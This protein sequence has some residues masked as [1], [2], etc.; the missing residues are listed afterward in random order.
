MPKSSNRYTL[1][2]VTTLCLICAGL[3]SFLAST[4][5]SKQKEA[6][7]LYQSKQMLIAARI[8][9]HRGFFLEDGVPVK[10]AT[11]SEITTF[12]KENIQPRLTDT[13]GNL[14]TFEEAGIDEE[15]YR[16][17][18]TKYGFSKL[19]YKLLYL[20]QKKEATTPD[21][22]IIPI[23]GYGLWD[24]IYGYIAIESDAD[25]ILGTTWYEQKETPGL[26]AEISTQAWQAQFYNKVVFQKN[27]DGNTDY[28]TA[29][30]GINIIKSVKELG[31]SPLADSS[32]DGVTGATET[33]RGVSEAYRN[34]LAQYRPFLIKA[35]EQKAN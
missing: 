16:R 9:N 24:A 25:T 7:E 12:V 30:L 33:M 23:N 18:N 35:N 19:K 8:L 15:V 1:L 21:A 31:D 27:A 32:V 26:G 10:K 2:F 34:C 5:S 6:Q 29:P 20:V 14:Y 17:E 28:K 3:L 22:Y 4:L 11:N 13:Q